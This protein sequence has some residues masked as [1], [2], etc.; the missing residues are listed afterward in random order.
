MACAERFGTEKNRKFA[1]SPRKG[2]DGRRRLNFGQSRTRLKS[3]Q[4]ACRRSKFG[5]KS[6]EFA[7]ELYAERDGEGLLQKPLRPSSLPP[8]GL[9]EPSPGRRG[10]MRKGVR[11]QAPEQMQLLLAENSDLHEVFGPGRHRQQAQKQRLVQRV[12]NLSSLPGIPKVCKMVRENN[13]S[14]RAPRSAAPPSID[15]GPETK[16]PLT[17]GLFAFLFVC[18]C[19]SSRASCSNKAS[20]A[21]AACSA[22]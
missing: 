18:E 20:A 1:P 9:G 7:A 2:E 22:A 15:G 5:G 17:W 10:R 6:R 13:A 21:M 4:I 3:R 19:Y 16:S 14:F 12:D 8:S 11:Q